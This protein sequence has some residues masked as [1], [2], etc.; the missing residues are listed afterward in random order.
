[1]VVAEHLHKSFGPVHAVRGVSFELAPGQVAALLGPNGAGKTTT[2]RM[3]VGFT[4]PDRGRVT[5]QGADTAASPAAARRQ[6]GYLPESTPL[7]PEMRV[8]EYL[9][10]RARLYGLQRSDRGPALS[11]VLERC[12]LKEVANRRIGHLSKGYKQRVGLAGALLHNPPVLVLDEPT[13]GLDPTQ[14]RETRQL[15]RELAA[16]RT[17]LVSSH[18]LPEVAVLC[19]RVIVISGGVVRADSPTER[20]GRA[21]GD[22]NSYVLQARVQR[23]ADEERFVKSMGNLPFV[24]EITRDGTRRQEGEWI[25]WR[26][27]AKAGSP[28]LREAIA[29]A[30][31]QGGFLLRELRGESPSLEQAFLRLIEPGSDG[32]TS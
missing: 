26:I 11:R 28:D 2:I 12:W 16:D 19:D 22:M 25:E 7:Y 18:I 10:Y 9:L 4:M 8:R 17:M 31:S 27:L 23:A 29:T 14:I 5:I 24:Q 3:I 15:V 1:M 30:A 6:I 13:N 20:L 21:P 32:G